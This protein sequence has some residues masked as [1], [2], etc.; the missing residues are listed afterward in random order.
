MSRFVFLWIE[1]LSF[2]IKPFWDSFETFVNTVSKWPEG[3]FL[4]L[5]QSDK[6][7]I[8]SNYFL[9]TFRSLITSYSHVDPIDFPFIQYFRFETR[10]FIEFYIAMPRI[11]FSKIIYLSIGYAFVFLFLHDQVLLSVLIS[12]LISFG[13]N[14]SVRWSIE[15]ND[16]WKE[17][18]GAY[19]MVCG[20]FYR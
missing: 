1:D 11:Y 17:F 9:I 14:P 3:T 2:L 8:L 12:H 18:Y 13:E 20:I 19:W 4:T 5:Y 15:L 7:S 10:C 6:A 16:F